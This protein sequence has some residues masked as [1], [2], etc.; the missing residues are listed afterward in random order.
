LRLELVKQ[1]KNYDLLKEQQ[2]NKGNQEIE[3]LKE[4]INVLKVNI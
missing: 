3:Q 4:Q 2:A 1:K